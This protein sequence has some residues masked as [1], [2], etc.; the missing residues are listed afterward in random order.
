MQKH[1]LYFAV[2]EKAFDS[3]PETLSHFGTMDELRQALYLEL[4][5]TDKIKKLD[6]SII[7]RPKSVSFAECDGAEFDRHFESM[8]N[9]LC[10]ILQCTERELMEEV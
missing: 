4:G 2:L 6:G 1:R 7:E 8:K 5:Y 10:K 9:I 3:L